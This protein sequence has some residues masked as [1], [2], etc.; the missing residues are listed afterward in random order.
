MISRM[1]GPSFVSSVPA[2][3]GGYSTLVVH[4][5]RGSCPKRMTV[6]GDVHVDERVGISILPL[7][8][9]FAHDGGASEE[10]LSCVPVAKDHWSIVRM[11]I[12]LH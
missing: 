11:N 10:L 9:F 7:N 8:G 12:W 3:E 4:D 2:V 1:L 6:R 5:L